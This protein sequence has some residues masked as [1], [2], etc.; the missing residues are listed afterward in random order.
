MQ[1]RSVFVV[2]VV[3]WPRFREVIGV[4][5]ERGGELPEYFRNDSR[6]DENI[7]NILLYLSFILFILLFVCI[8]KTSR[9]H[10]QGKKF[11]IYTY[12]YIQV[13][14]FLLDKNH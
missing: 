13:C 2:V 5:Y 9:L 14:I 7:Q 3:E 10:I 11:I 4:G 8:L 1:F 6:R 12:M